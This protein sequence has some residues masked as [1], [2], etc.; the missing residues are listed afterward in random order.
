MD[1][2][3]ERYNDFVALIS[4][5]ADGLKKR[6]FSKKFKLKFSIKN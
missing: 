2:H 6:I 1:R 5:S 3:T 4:R